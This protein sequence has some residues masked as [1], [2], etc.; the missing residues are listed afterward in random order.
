MST[1]FP[2][3]PEC[4]NQIIRELAH[5]STRNSLVA[6]LLVN[7]HVCSWTL[8]I[9]Y[10]GPLLVPVLINTSESSSLTAR[11]L[12][13]LA[14][15]FQ[16]IPKSH[17]SDLLRAAY[18][19]PGDPI[20]HERQQ[21]QQQ[22]QESKLAFPYH[23]F[24]TS[25]SLTH[26]GGLLEGQFHCPDLLPSRTLVDFVKQNGLKERYFDE[27][28]LAPVV[29]AMQWD[30]LHLGIS[31]DLRRDLTW[32]LCSE[33]ERVKSLSISLTDIGRY[34]PLVP[35][36]KSLSNVNFLLDRKMKNTVDAVVLTPRQLKLLD[37]RREERTLHLDQMIA[38]VQE[39]QRFHHGVLR[40]ASC[41]R[42]YF[43]EP[44]PTQY[45]QQLFRL[46]PTLVDPQ[47]LNHKNWAHVVANIKEINLSAVRSIQLPE[48]L[49]GDMALS[50][51]LRRTPFLHRCRSLEK[52]YMSS[53]DED[54]F[55][56][57]VDERRRRDADIA[58]GCT[59]EQPPVP[60]QHI[61]IKYNRPLNGRL[62][63]SLGCGFS[64]T[65]RSIR[66][67]SFR[68]GDSPELG[69]YAGHCSFGGGI[70]SLRWNTPRLCELHIETN[71]NFLCVHPSLLLGAPNLGYLTLKDKRT[72]YA[73]TDIV[74]WKAADLQCLLHLQLRGTSALSFHPDTLNNTPNLKVLHLETL[75]TGRNNSLTPLPLPVDE[76]EEGMEDDGAG[77]SS[78]SSFT[79]GLSPRRRP[80]WT[81]DWELPKLTT[82]MLN[83]VFARQFQFKMLAGTPS[84]QYLRVTLRHS[85]PQYRRNVEVKEFLASTTH[86]QRRIEGV[87]QNDNNNNDDPIYSQQ[88]EYIH[89]P[90]MTDCDLMGSWN[91]DKDVLEILCSKV[92]PSTQNLCL[93]GC[94]GFDM[95]EWVSITSRHLTRLR[96]T[97]AS[98]P[99]TPEAVSAAGLLVVDPRIG[100]MTYF[101]LAH[102]TR[103]VY[104]VHRG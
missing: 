70:S 17:V 3:P 61:D 40:T 82:L 32:A 78:T 36:F 27:E 104:G 7:K 34:L 103:R 84:L 14:T 4:L 85:S 86:G 77:L 81:W 69:Q 31:L 95:I 58:A 96:Q 51:V 6:L 91:L 60:L 79:S 89:L 11:R 99:I 42:L 38:F 100:N 76:V 64:K 54:V 56:W 62:F 98:V 55:Q 83:T 29:E 45:E 20:D 75:V 49:K 21:Q 93:N 37:Q 71:I 63:D 65:L 1:T 72:E 35:R 90:N 33:V 23:M 68:S 43:F 44:C 5:R 46:L 25:A 59:P 2:L 52:M 47:F 15:L 67:H 87:M 50:Q 10:E 92:A 73:T 94:S 39:H 24:V 16:T 88:P 30:T 8:P 19:Q 12:R 66:V 26:C 80:I 97:F 22:Q 53:V 102:Q 9:L 101:R 18:P 28:P 57:A 74:P 13:L 41:E 48:H